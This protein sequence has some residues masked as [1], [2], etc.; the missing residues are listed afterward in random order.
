MESLVTQ[1]VMPASLCRMTSVGVQVWGQVGGLLGGKVN[2]WVGHAG[3]RWVGEQV[4][5]PGGGR[6][7]G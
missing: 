6:Q 4:G 3:N 2:R 7:G 1:N 5:E